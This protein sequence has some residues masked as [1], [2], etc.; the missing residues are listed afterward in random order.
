MDRATAC[1]AVGCAFESRRGYWFLIVNEFPKSLKNINI[2]VQ[3][4]K[5]GLAK[6]KWPGRMELIS[7]RPRVLLDGAQNKASAQALVEGIRENFKYE[8]LILLFGI[9]RDKNIEEVLNTISPKASRIILT[10]AD[11]PRSA[12]PEDLK[13]VLERISTIEM[14]K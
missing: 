2:S 3:A 7:S 14:K 6:V 5:K 9:S 12:R 8:N 10:S 4:V 13:Q 1:G 11:N